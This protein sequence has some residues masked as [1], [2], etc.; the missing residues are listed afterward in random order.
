MDQELLKNNAI[1]LGCVILGRNINSTYIG[2][3]LTVGGIVGLAAYNT[4]YIGK[5]DRI[6]HGGKNKDRAA[7]AKDLFHAGKKI[8]NKI[9]KT[10]GVNVSINDRVDGIVKANKCKTELAASDIERGLNVMY[11]MILG[12]ADPVREEIK[13]TLRKNN[14]NKQ[15]KL[16]AKMRKKYNIS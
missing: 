1:G 11:D 6:A 7:K 4:W 10:V 9:K 14:K 13:I 2:G 12:G 16:R 3:L 8:K 5:S 15:A